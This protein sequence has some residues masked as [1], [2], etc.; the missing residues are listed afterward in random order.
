MTLWEHGVLPLQWGVAF[1]ASFAAALFDLRY[2]RVPNWLTGPLLF[3]GVLFAATV[4]G[5]RG[6]GDSL[7]ACLL[8]S[9]PFVILFLFAGGGAGDAKLMGALGAW[10]GVINGAVTL[11]AV[12]LAGLL[13][14]LGFALA[15]RQVT[16]VLT[17][18]VGMVR[19]VA[20]VVLTRG[21]VR[22]G[23]I[24]SVPSTQAL[25]VPYAVAVFI[26]VSLAMA[27]VLIWRA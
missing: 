24:G 17:N 3:S 14:A 16:A 19:S 13:L 2:R 7:L 1:S 8:L 6:L 12:C 11:A 21:S 26:G 18:V 22:L 9:F 15:S 27:G 5:W 4:G 23:E 20:V 25:T 10:L